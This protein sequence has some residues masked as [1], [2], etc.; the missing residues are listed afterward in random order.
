MEP[1]L[2]STYTPSCRRQGQVSLYYSLPKQNLSEGPKV[3]AWEPSNQALNLTLDFWNF[4]SY[5]CIDRRRIE[6]AEMKLLRP[7]AGYTLH[8]HKTNDF[9]RR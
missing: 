6:V 9:I 4:S 3:E 7:L 8:D 1:Y 5:V 2:C